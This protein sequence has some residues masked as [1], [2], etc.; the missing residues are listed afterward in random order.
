VEKIIKKSKQKKQKKQN[1]VRKHCR[2]PQYF[3]KEA[4]VVILNQLNINKIKLTKIIFKKIIKKTKIIWGNTIGIN[5]VL[6][7]KTSKLNSQ[8][9]QY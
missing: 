9:A 4:I 8:P 3:V 6:K 2:N 1:H 7:K 5:I